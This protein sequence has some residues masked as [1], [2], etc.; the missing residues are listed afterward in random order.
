MNFKCYYQTSLLLL[1]LPLTTNV[2]LG[3]STNTT[4]EDWKCKWCEYPEGV[5][6]DVEL[7]IGYV[8]D[9]AYRFGNQT[10]LN[11][12]GP[13]FIGN[14]SVH[15]QDKAA[16]Y[17]DFEARNFGTDSRWLSAQGGQQ[18]KSTYWFEYAEIPSLT[19]DSARSP[20]IGKSSDML[21]LPDDW[22]PADTTEAMPT[23]RNNL[24]NIELNNETT[25][26]GFGTTLHTGIYG[27]TYTLKFNRRHKEGS[28]AIGVAYGSNDAFS[29]QAALLPA[30]IDY[31]TDQLEVD[32]AYATSNWQA[33]LGYYGSF[34]KNDNDSLVWQN[35]YS[36]PT[37]DT[38]SG[39]LALAP[40]NEFHQLHFSGGYRLSSTTRATWYSATGIL[41]QDE[42]FLPYTSNPSLNTSNLPERSLDAKARTWT[43]NT[44]IYSQPRPKLSWDV[45]YA[46]HEYDNKVNQANWDYVVTDA[47]QSLV[48]RRNP[49]Y[50]YRN[51]SLK[52]KTRYRM[53][54]NSNILAGIDYRINERNNQ[55]VNKTKEQT[56]WAK[57]RYKPS[58]T[59]DAAFKL[60]NA[61][62]SADDYQSPASI[63]EPENTLLRKYHLADRDRNTLGAVLSYM[64]LDTLNLGLNADYSADDYNDSPLGL[65]NADHYRYSLDLLYTL[66][67]HLSFSVFY[68]QEHYT[69]KQAGSQTYSTPDWYSKNKDAIYTLGIGI[70]QTSAQHPVEWGIDYVHSNAD[71][72]QTLTGNI[73]LNKQ[74]LP[75]TN[76]R[77][78]QLQFYTNYRWQK[79]L[80]LKLSIAYEKYDE[81][82]FAVDGVNVDTY[83]QLLS[84]GNTTNDYEA[85]V[86][87]TT[88]RYTF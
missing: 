39:R 69:S 47:M 68:T 76:N 66:T 9:D 14:A 77:L 27:E 8:T 59:V 30:P 38:G 35:P 64:P 48:Q 36:D 44:T 58:P 6:G 2:A 49:V 13:Y 52:A 71:E 15:Y 74:S 5:W 65:T 80:K 81:D 19:T 42:N 24:R 16:N 50:S 22:I 21:S 4:P 25:T 3:E 79:N 54:S 11:D 88:I 67:Q 57:W 34:F 75:E 1:L 55:A 86:V 46:H 12:K 87:S 17:W 82:D 78:Q 31:I 26:Y 32:V 41:L 61:Q 53:Y 7:G 63:T 20:F 83:P 18:G 70:R 84:L 51:R 23:L 72:N 45:N 40:E 62:R 33:R 29:S 28:Q 60:A 73:D 37:S 10:G 43:L 56:I 85:Y